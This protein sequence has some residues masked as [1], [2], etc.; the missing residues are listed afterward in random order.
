MP[1]VGVAV[2]KQVSDNL[3]RITGLSVT[4]GA[5][6]TIGLAT[7]VAASD[8][9][10]PA[11]FQPRPYDLPDAAADVSLDEAISVSFV[12]VGQQTSQPAPDVSKGG[13]PQ[14]FQIAFSVGGIIP[15]PPLPPGTTGEIEI[16]VRFH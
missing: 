6:G 4:Q 14:T 5:A 12:P 16:Y 10:L 15:E 3:V 8:V 11:G 1:F 13:T 9:V 7:T 2:V